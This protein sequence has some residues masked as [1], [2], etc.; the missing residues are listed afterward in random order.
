MLYSAE[1]GVAMALSKQLLSGFIWREWKA[2]LN[3]VNQQC[4]SNMNILSSRFYYSWNF[5]CS[6]I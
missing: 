2:Q 1:T 3:T 6:D 4:S 5:L